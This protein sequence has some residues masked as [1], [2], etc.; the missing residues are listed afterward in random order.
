MGVVIDFN[1]RTIIEIINSTIKS[2][3]VNEEY[4]SSCQVACANLLKCIN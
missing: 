2:Y 1:I 4:N 3:P